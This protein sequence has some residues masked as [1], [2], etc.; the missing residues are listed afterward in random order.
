MRCG[1]RG[2][3]SSLPDRP[4]SSF[5]AAEP[6]FRSMADRGHGLRRRLTSLVLLTFLVALVQ[7]LTAV[8]ALSTTDLVD[9]RR[10]G[11]RPRPVPAEH[12]PRR[13]RALVP[14]ARGLTWSPDDMWAKVAIDHVAGTYDWMRDFGPDRN[15]NWRFRPDAFET[16]ER[17]ARAIVKAFAPDEEPDPVRHVHRP[18][19]VRPVLSMGGGRRGTRLDGSR[20]PAVASIRRRRHGTEHP[21]LARPRARDGPDGRGPRPPVDD[22]RLRLRRRPDRSGSTS[23]RCDSASDSTTRLTNRKT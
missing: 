4:R 22:R 19:C 11:L 10:R 1:R 18:R 14:T 7:S 9:R 6:T 15:G 2:P 16:R 23:W 12:L 21:S 17:W 3:P 8:T 20:S 13:E 5:R